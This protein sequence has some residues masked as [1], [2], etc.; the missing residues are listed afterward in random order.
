MAKKSKKKKT[1]PIQLPAVQGKKGEIVN[2][3]IE[4]PMGSR[5]KFKY[6]EEMGFFKL[7]G[8]LPQGMM[9]PHAFGFVPSTR[10]ADGDPED[11]LVIMDEPTF[12]GCV[13]PTRLLGVIEA[14]QTEPGQQQPERNDRLI[15]VAAGSRDY[16][17]FKTLSDLNDNMLEEIEQFFVNY[18]QERGKKFKV[19]G[20][21]G[22]KQAWKLLKKSQKAA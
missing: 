17:D 3:V 8:V 20:Q 6:D 5:N 14:E 13:V 2:A 18:N 19:L 10:A 4:T 16:S 1:R 9:F 7:S 21:K 11:V 22:P 12:T 15:G